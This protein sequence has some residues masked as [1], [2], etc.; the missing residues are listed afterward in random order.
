LEEKHPI[1]QTFTPKMGSALVFNH[2]TLHEGEKV[3]KGVK[4]IMRTSI[5]FRQVED[6]RDP[7]RPFEL[8]ELW[9]KTKA[10]FATFNQLEANKDPHAFSTKFLEAQTL[11]I[12]HGRSIRG[13]SSASKGSSEV[14]PLLDVLP[15]E[16]LHYILEFLP[17]P[18]DLC[19]LM[20]VC[21]RMKSVARD[22][23]LW[24]LNYTKRWGSDTLAILESNFRREVEPP[25]PSSRPSS[26]QSG[27]KES[28]Q[29]GIIDPSLMDWCGIY[30]GRH[31]QEH[32]Y[33]VPLVVYISDQMRAVS[34]PPTTTT[35]TP[36][37]TT[38]TTT[39]SP[40][41]PLV[42][43]ILP[44]FV[45]FTFSPWDNSF[46]SYELI[47]ES[48]ASFY[49]SVSDRCEVSFEYLMPL[50]RGAYYD[51]SQASNREHLTLFVIHPLYFSD[52]GLIPE[53][54][55]ENDY[56]TDTKVDIPVDIFETLTKKVIR[57]IPELP[58]ITYVSA[59]LCAL[60]SCK[61]STG[62]VA[63]ELHLSLQD[64]E[65]QNRV[66]WRVVSFDQSVSTGERTIF[67]SATNCDRVVDTIGQLAGDTR[68]VVAI[69]REVAFEKR[70]DSP[71][72]PKI[73]AS[74]ADTA[75]QIKAKLAATGFADVR[76][77]TDEHIFEGARAYAGLPSF[78]EIVIN[79]ATYRAN[80]KSKK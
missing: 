6:L 9:Q 80:L 48:W 51:A 61:V 73:R 3:V 66:I 78:Q 38:T 41:S 5:M 42:D 29:K 28:R 45:D 52:L 64:T 68:P 76:E 69:A 21:S 54:I 19:T 71:D 77:L 75:K 50:W 1:V 58:A 79:T 22:G 17:A 15:A 4:Y 23:Y 8:D 24:R 11:Q 20:Q 53:G 59:E 18:K 27:E 12:L 13:A 70:P 62:I 33:N 46:E 49:S 65:E 16:L 26:N 40:P 25:P 43:T 14:V 60:Y 31:T 35:T 2:D 32:R 67:T 72:L 37:T 55:H 36:T 30:R 10:I 63:F 44:A 7:A 74:C 56:E 39:P 57:Q 34:V 47:N